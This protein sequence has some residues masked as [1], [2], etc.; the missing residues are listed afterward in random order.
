MDC[1]PSLCGAGEC[2]AGKPFFPAAYHEPGRRPA[3]AAAVEGAAAAVEAFQ[4]APSLHIARKR[5]TELIER[6]TSAIDYV[7]K[8][9]D[10]I[11]IISG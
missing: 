1:Q 9:P 10:R 11:S 5:L 4:S 8:N 3:F 6:H 7:L 2:R